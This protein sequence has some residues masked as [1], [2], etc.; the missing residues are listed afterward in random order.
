[1]KRKKDILIG[2]YIFKYYLGACYRIYL[3]A[4]VR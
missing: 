1:M 3:F 2:D 4:M